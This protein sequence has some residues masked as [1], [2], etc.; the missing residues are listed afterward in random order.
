[1]ELDGLVKNCHLSP[2]YRVGFFCFGCRSWQAWIDRITVRM[3][4]I[5]HT[6]SM[7]SPESYSWNKKS[8][9]YAVIRL[10]LRQE[11]HFAHMKHM[12]V[13]SG[14]HVGHCS[15]GHG[16]QVS[17]TTTSRSFSVIAEW[18]KT[19]RVMYTLSAMSLDSNKNLVELWGTAWA[20]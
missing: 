7:M 10:F 9:W 20:K 11:S 13:T 14:E 19:S 15:G 16:G 1:M 2:L 3:K 4:I 17:S 18:S 12:V 5:N 6:S 8:V